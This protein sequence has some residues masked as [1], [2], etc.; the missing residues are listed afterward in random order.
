MKGHPFPSVRFPALRIPVGGR[1]PCVWLFVQSCGRPVNR[2][3]GAELD[4]QPRRPGLGVEGGPPACLPGP[5]WVRSGTWSSFPGRC[6]LVGHPP[7]RHPAQ[8]VSAIR[9]HCYAPVST[10][11]CTRELLRVPGGRGARALPGWDGSHCPAASLSSPGFH[12]PVVKRRQEEHLKWYF[13]H[14]PFSKIFR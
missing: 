3:G 2:F 9:G 6:P 11:L 12:V 4:S 1:V 10:W 7:P 5:P 8:C 14:Q 13:T